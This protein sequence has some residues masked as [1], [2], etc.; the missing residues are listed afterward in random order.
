MERTERRH[1]LAQVPA[2]AELGDHDLDTLAGVTRMVN[3]EPREQLFRKG[4]AGHEVYV[5]ASG[6]LKVVVTS[7]DGTDVVLAL[8]ER[9]EVFGELAVFAGGER[10][11]SVTAANSARLLALHRR[12][13]LQIL[14]EHPGI[15][16]QMLEELALRLQRITK[17]VEDTIF[18][19]LPPRLAKKLLELADHH[20]EKVDDGLRIE[21]QLTQQDL[22]DMVGSSRESIN[23]LIGFWRT[24][25]WMRNEGSR[26]VLCQPAKFERLVEAESA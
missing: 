25:G 18:L 3:L 6:T 4:D 2:F 23:K 15:A 1:L 16:I 9:G 19:N 12:D 5:I 21:L 8:M 13:F 20:G 11:A 14:R 26:Y 7:K 10:T 22:A 24:E 17:F